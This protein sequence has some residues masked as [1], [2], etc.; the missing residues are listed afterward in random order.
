ME[1]D[2]AYFKVL[3]CHLTRGTGE[4]HEKPVRRTNLW[5]QDLNLEPPKYGGA[6][7]T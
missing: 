6:L 1:V 2:V 4:N 7:P 3:P 5:V